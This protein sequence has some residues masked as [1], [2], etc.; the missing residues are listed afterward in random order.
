MSFLLGNIKRTDY[1]KSLK[2]FPLDICEVSN[3]H[4]NA[5]CGSKTGY[6]CVC[7]EDFQGNGTFC[8]GIWKY[9]SRYNTGPLSLT[10]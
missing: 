3:C 6:E 5:R 10:S 4:Q 8:E 9:T 1:I 7:H 2:Y